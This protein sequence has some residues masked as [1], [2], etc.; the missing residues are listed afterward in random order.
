MAKFDGIPAPSGADPGI[1]ETSAVDW[2]RLNDNLKGISKG[3][4]SVYRVITAG[5]GSETCD[6]VGASSGSVALRCLLL[7]LRTRALVVSAPLG[8]FFIFFL[9][10]LYDM[11]HKTI[12]LRMVRIYP[13]SPSTGRD[14]RR[15][16]MGRGWVFSF[17]TC[18]T[19]I[20][21]A[22]RHGIF[23]PV[24]QKPGAATGGHGV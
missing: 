13:L 21:F 17:F 4:Q 22:C 6:S 14:A 12:Y 3:V 8:R 2:L 20:P 18:T 9:G 7:L 16:V 1:L 24:T 5:G 15:E 11:T 10:F 23:C 19:T